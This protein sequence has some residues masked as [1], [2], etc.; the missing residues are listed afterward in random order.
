MTGVLLIAYSGYFASALWIVLL[1][2]VITTLCM[3]TLLL[4]L[5]CIAFFMQNASD[6]IKELNLNAII[7][8]GQPNAAYSGAFKIF[9]FTIL[10]VAFLSYFPVEYFRTGLWHYLLVTFAGTGI[11]FGIAYSLF[12]YGLRR[13]ESGNMMFTRQ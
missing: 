9:T 1:L 13:Y 10:P 6:F 11:F 3:F 12:K 7:V 2:M 8:A 5:S 4:Y